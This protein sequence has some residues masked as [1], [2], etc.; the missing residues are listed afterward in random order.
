MGER[1]AF[2]RPLHLNNAAIFGHHHV[3]VGFRCGIFDV[4][5]IANGFAVNDTNGHRG[6]H[7]LHWVGF[8]LAGCHQFVQRIGQRHAGPGNRRRTGAAI[9][10]QHIAVECDGEFTQRFQVN[11]RAQRASD[12]TLNFH[13]PAALLAFC[14]FTRVTR[15][16]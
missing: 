1:L 5:Q 13:R 6:N 8:Q 15:V 9:G 14:C 4:L 11:R 10:L 16:R 7:P 2:C 3:H 12:Q